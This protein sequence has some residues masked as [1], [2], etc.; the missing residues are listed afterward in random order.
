MDCIV[1]GFVTG[2]F[3]AAVVTVISVS[4]LIVFLKYKIC[5]FLDITDTLSLSNIM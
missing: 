2:I 4:L 1:V 5:E 3:S